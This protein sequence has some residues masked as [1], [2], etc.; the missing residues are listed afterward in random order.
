[1]T[2]NYTFSNKEQFQQYQSAFRAFSR[3]KNV[4]A[5]EHILYNFIRNKD[6]K[7]GFT[8]ITNSKKL[9]V[10]TNYRRSEWATFDTMLADLKNTIHGRKHIKE[11]FERYGSKL[12]D[13]RP[14]L[15]MK[16]QDVI[17]EEMWDSIYTSLCEVT[18]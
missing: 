4:S 13:A 2:T 16:Y 3:D 1:M 8:P 12:A 5:Q 9:G 10:G 18:K 6:L 17:S 14:P 7:R 15:C 11:W